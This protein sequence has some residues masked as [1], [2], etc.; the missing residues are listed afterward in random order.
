MCTSH[1]A[2]C[3]CTVHQYAQHT[4][5]FTMLLAT[6]CSHSIDIQYTIHTCHICSAI[7]CCLYSISA[8]LVAVIIASIITRTRNTFSNITR[9]LLYLFKKAAE[10]SFFKELSF[11][12]VVVLSCNVNTFKIY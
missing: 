7:L 8:C 6:L 2:N 4:D 11:S 10:L 3:T 5:T 12:L 9:N 1:T